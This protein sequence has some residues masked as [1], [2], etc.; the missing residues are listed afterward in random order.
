MEKIKVK[1][2]AID[3]LHM[4]KL[5][6]T[7]KHFANIILAY[8]WSYSTQHPMRAYRYFIRLHHLRK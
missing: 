2:A 1:V 4:K 8:V 7:K 3:F 6:K 5:K